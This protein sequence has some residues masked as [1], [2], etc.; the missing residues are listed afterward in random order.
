MAFVSNVSAYLGT[1]ALREG[2]T[3]PPKS[4]TVLTF[5]NGMWY[6]FTIYCSSL[7]QNKNSL[8]FLQEFS[9]MPGGLS[10]GKFLSGFDFVGCAHK[11]EP[12]FLFFI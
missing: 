3:V 5:M 4:E 9:M 10:R 1:G 11:I 6:V 7:R 2:I 12:T 8:N